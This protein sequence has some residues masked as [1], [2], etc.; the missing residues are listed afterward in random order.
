MWPQ[1]K[2]GKLL[3][4]VDGAQKARPFFAKVLI[5]KWNEPYIWGAF[6][7]TF[8]ED[9]STAYAKCLFRGLRISRDVGFSLALH[10]K[11]MLYLASTQRFS[12]AKREALTVSDYRISQGW[13]ESNI[14]EQQRGKEWFNVEPADNNEELYLE[15]SAG[16]EQ[17]VFPYAEKTNF[18]VEWKDDEKVLMGIASTGSRESESQ[19]ALRLRRVNYV[20]VPEWAK[21]LRRTAIKDRETMRELEVGACYTGVLSQDGKTILGGIESCVS[22]EFANRFTIEFEGT[23][24]L[25]GYRDKQGN[26]KAIAFVR[27]TQRGSIFVP[28][29]L[30]QNSELDTFDIVK[31]TARAIFK[32]DRWS[33]E[34]TSIE[35]LGKP[36]PQ[37][38]E[39]RD[40]RGI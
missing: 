26:D 8:A 31:G 2:F 23:F 36:D 11:A 14:V 20:Y 10:E 29:N 32:D 18:Y 34:T 17:Y 40:L 19:L 35:F 16:A 37:D 30:F 1:Y 13:P 4:Q 7:D 28:P 12:E 6:A 25:V 15:M 5:R 24:D 33:M 22:E 21:G 38:V 27:D 9:D 3:M 39:K